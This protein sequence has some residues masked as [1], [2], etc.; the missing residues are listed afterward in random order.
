MTMPPDDRGEQTEAPWPRPT[1]HRRPSAPAG[2][3]ASAES[4]SGGQP[5]Q[6]SG[7]GGT[8][9]TPSP[10]LMR[11]HPPAWRSGTAAGG[12]VPPARPRARRPGAAPPLDAG[13]SRHRIGRPLGDV[14]PGEYRV[15][16]GFTWPDGDRPAQD[17]GHSHQRDE[18]PQPADGYWLDGDPGT[19]GPH[20]DSSHSDS[21][22]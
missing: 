13:Y 17:P 22:H 14:P 15:P 6:S 19:N 16:D 5:P 18:F 1:R 11:G 20:S 7:T 4:P 9:G 3:Q 8:T 10:D 2:S 12:Y 21:P